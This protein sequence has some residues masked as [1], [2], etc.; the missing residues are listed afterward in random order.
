MNFLKKLFG[1]VEVTPEEEK[2]N[3]QAK[4]FDV[5]KYEIGRAHV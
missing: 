3:Q 4:D 1:S 2:K 5:L